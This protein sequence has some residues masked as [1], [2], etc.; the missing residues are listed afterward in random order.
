MNTHAIASVSV[1]DMK[2]N[3][4]NRWLKIII[5]MQVLVIIVMLAIPA[6]LTYSQLAQVRPGMTLQDAKRLLGEPSKK[7]SI[8]H[9]M[10]NFEVGNY[11]WEH[12][13]ILWRPTRSASFPVK[14][15]KFAENP[16]SIWVGCSHLLWIQTEGEVIVY[17][18]IAPI[19]CSGGGIQGCM[20]TIRQ[21]WNEWWK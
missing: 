10:M 2:L 8:H 6:E 15:A 18:C 4:H 21:Y 1:I 9:V 3:T 16:P 14:S 5:W 19:T 12:A 11:H 7:G 13:G 17:V 20:D